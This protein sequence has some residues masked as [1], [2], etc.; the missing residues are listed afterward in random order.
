VDE[1]G[2]V[3]H[4]QGMEPIGDAKIGNGDVLTGASGRSKG[5]AA[6]RPVARS[7]DME[8]RRRD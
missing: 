3:L 6:K 7:K 1:T 2:G 5:K 8:M 4:S